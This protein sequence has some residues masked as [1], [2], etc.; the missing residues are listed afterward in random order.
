MTPAALETIRWMVI[1][2]VNAMHLGMLANALAASL[3]GAPEGERASALDA[4]ASAT[5]SAALSLS[6]L[7]FA[8]LHPE[9]SALVADLFAERFAEVGARVHRILSG[10]ERAALSELWTT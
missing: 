10:R 1:A 4:M 2:E 6:R 5:S 9:E 3:S 7:N 8:G